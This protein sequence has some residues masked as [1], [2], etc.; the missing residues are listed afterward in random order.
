MDLFNNNPAGCGVLI[1]CSDSYSIED[2]IRLINVL[3][4][5]YR[6][7]CTLRA[8]RKNQYRIYIKQTSMSLTIRKWKSLIYKKKNYYYL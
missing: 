2:T 6:L 8:H 4:I 3:I 1:I 7:E 5:K